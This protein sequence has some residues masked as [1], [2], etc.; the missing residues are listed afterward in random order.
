MR[1]GLQRESV[2]GRPRLHTER[3]AELEQTVHMTASAGREG[4][5]SWLW[6]HSDSHMKVRVSLQTPLKQRVPPGQQ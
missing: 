4:R 5:T 2:F 6:V 1:A 3:A